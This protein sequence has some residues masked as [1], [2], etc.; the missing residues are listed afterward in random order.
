MSLNAPY[1]DEIEWPHGLEPFDA[2]SFK[3]QANPF[4]HFA[5][6][7]ENAPVLKARTPTGDLW[8]ISRYQDVQMALRSP[9]I[10]SSSTFDP[11]VLPLIL[12]MDPPRHTRLRETV[13]RAFTPK[14]VAR[15]EDQIRQLAVRYFDPMMTNG[16]GDVVEDFAVQLTIGTIGALLGIPVSETA[17]LKSWTDDLA[18]YFGRVARR[19]PGSPG[20]KE[21]VNE[22]LAF[23]KSVLEQAVKDE[24]ETVVGNLARLWKSGDMDEADALHFCAFLFGAGHET[25][26]ILIAN[27]FLTL[28]EQP[29]LLGLLQQ[30]ETKIAKF[31]DEL[32][33]FRAAPQRL[34]RITTQDTEVQGYLV[35]EGSHV[36]LLPGSA[37]RDS[38]K[39][40]DGERFDIDRDTTGHIGFGYGIHAC[41]GAWLA[42]LE[43]QIAFQL[44][45]QRLSAVRL[46][47][48]YPVLFYQGGTLSNTGPR[49]LHVKLTGQ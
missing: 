18:N 4:P 48:N 13:A 44:V 8:F 19:A 49:S 15:F 35:P 34:S 7:R 6:M 30:D 12:L 43:A 28:C 39:F 37:N 22:F 17:R 47:G 25:T 27:G 11:D 5:W 21:G 9:K 38:A 33:R 24:D 26:T 3:I 14:A 20:D 1:T 36:R 41:I 16:G 42:R 2:N 40:P 29:R 46:D 45:A 32:V 31:V 23:L 10:F